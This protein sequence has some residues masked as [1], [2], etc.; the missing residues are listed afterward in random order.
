MAALFFIL[1]IYLCV[2]VHEFGHFLAAKHFGIKV[3]SFNLGFGKTLLQKEKNGTLYRFNLLPLGGYCLIDDQ[4][5]NK[6]KT[7]EKMFVMFAG[8]LMNIILAAISFLLIAV[9]SGNTDIV[10]IGQTFINSISTTF[11]SFAYYFK[12]FFT[13]QSNLK[14]NVDF[15]DAVINGEGG[16]TLFINILSI[17]YLVNLSLAIFNLLPI[18]ALDGGQ[19]LFSVPELFHRSIPK[20]ISTAINGVCFTALMGFMLITIFRDLFVGWIL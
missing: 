19:I 4:S 5:F 14:N 17:G 11:E 18:P 9:L 10:L 3:P 6:A 13:S 12:T 16:L 1:M 15:I 2:V 7:K 8:P 20:S